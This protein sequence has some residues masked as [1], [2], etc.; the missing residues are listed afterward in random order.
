MT[1]QPAADKTPE[2]VLLDKSLMEKYPHKYVRDVTIGGR[3]F[4]FRPI[5]PDDEDMMVKM[6]STFSKETIFHRFFTTVTMQPSKATRFTHIDYKRQMAIVCEEE[7]GGERHLVG[8][9]RYNTSPE[10][11]IEA[12]MAIVIG[13]PWQGKG[14]GAAL[15]NYLLE[16]AELEGFKKLYGLVHYD[17]MAVPRMFDKM[18]RP[19][20]AESTGTELRFEVVL[21]EK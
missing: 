18:K 19:H 7:T 6:F 8:V 3:P 15:L 17:N 11:D 9:A 12:E 16:I 13:D 14:V 1:D 21:S 20:R 4:R 5:R 10:S 2:H